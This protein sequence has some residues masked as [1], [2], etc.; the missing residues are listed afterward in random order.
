MQAEQSSPGP[1]PNRKVL[2]LC[3]AAICLI[4]L[5][6]G[7][8]AFRN[9]SSSSDSTPSDSAATKD[10]AGSTSAEKM[11]LTRNSQTDTEGPKG[12]FIYIYDRGPNGEYLISKSWHKD[13]HEESDAPAGRDLWIQDANG[14]ERLI[15][16][17]VYR[18]KF[19][20]DGNKIAYTTADVVMFIEDLAGNKVAEVPRAYEPNWHPNSSSVVYARVPEDRPVHI[21]E[22]LGISTYDITTG[23][24]KNITD[25]K[26]DDVR[27]HYSPDG[28]WVL[29]VSGGRTGLA[30]F[31]QVPVS[32]G[33]PVQVTNSGLEEVN[34]RFVPTPYDRTVWTQDRRWFVYDFKSGDRHEIWGLNFDPHGHFQGAVNFGEGLDPQLSD[35]GRTLIAQRQDGDV[36][37]PVQYTL[38]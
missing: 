10:P 33:E 36:S 24:T 22:V 18:A 15:A 14:N 23:Q 2:L 29:F 26:T 6:I 27:P 9:A 16:E 34:D 4:C 20:P 19:S 37:R 7:S 3:L 35:D 21:P 25:G 13:A 32:G 31:W 28:D 8:K 38:P 1:G 12:P 11:A 30:S 5:F 17:N